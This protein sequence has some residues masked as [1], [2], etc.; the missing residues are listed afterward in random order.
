MIYKATYSNVDTDLIISVDENNPMSIKIKFTY[1]KDD[2]VN[3]EKDYECSIPFESDL[4]YNKIISLS[5]V[6]C[7]KI[8]VDERFDD[9]FYY[10]TAIWDLVDKVCWF[11]IPAN[12]NDSA[13]LNSIEIYTKGGAN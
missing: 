5:L 7:A 10:E 1:F 3:I 4:K 13:G 6:K 8:I 12:Y 11:T 9:P 2:M